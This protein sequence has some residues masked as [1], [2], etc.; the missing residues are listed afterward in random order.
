MCYKYDVLYYKYE[1]MYYKTLYQD[2]LYFSIL[3]KKKNYWV[4]WRSLNKLNV[5]LLKII[6]I[7]VEDNL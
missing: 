1:V 6:F 3:V 4:S 7:W 5:N 2:C